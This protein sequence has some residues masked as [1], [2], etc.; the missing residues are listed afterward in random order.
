MVVGVAYLYLVNQGFNNL[1]YKLLCLITFGSMLFD[2]IWIF[3]YSGHWMSGSG[4]ADGAENGVKRFAA[5]MSIVLLI[6][7]VPIAIIFWRN[8]LSLSF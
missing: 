3:M 7:K 4:F 5:F 8:S 6:C 2:L 1:I